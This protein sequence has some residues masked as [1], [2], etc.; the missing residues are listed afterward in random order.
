MVKVGPRIS[1]IIRRSGKQES[2]KFLAASFTGST[3]LSEPPLTSKDPQSMEPTCEHS[4]C[5]C[6][7]IRERL[8]ALKR[9]SRSVPCHASSTDCARWELKKLFENGTYYIP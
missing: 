8:G 1:G 9:S 2:Q 4:M 3:A 5:V 7:K 6:A